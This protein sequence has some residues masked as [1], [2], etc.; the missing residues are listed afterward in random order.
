MV[1]GGARS[2]KSRFAL[3][4]VTRNYNK[5]AFIATAVPFDEEMKVR[6]LEHKTARDKSFLT[7]EE[8]YDLAH[9]L[10]SVPSNVDCVIIDCLTVWQSNLM[11]RNGAE[12][13]SFPEVRTFLD[14]LKKPSCDLMIVTNETGMGIVPEHAEARRF[15]DLAGKLNQDTAALADSV[16]LIVCGRPI[17]IK[18]EK[19]Y[20]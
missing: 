6:I 15:R 1:T 5:K 12:K 19:Q 3:E 16:I 18:G 17:V 4:Y 10:D 2:G 20:E 7:I 9:A 13:D 11:H 14:K 8:P